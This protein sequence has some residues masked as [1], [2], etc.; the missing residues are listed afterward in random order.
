MQLQRREHTR[1]HGLHY[2]RAESN[3][4]GLACRV[5]GGRPLYDVDEVLIPLVGG[6]ARGRD[7]LRLLIVAQVVLRL[8][9]A[10]LT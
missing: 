9:M 1:G 8:T 4:E 3:A 2:T 5:I 6:R 7:H 10:E